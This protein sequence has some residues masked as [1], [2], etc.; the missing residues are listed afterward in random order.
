MVE[1]ENHGNHTGI[2]LNSH[3][4]HYLGP[5]CSNNP[6]FNT[7]GQDLLLSPAEIRLASA[8]FRFNYNFN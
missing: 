6:G 8:R 3:S 5:N 2:W 1:Y 4:M 7:I